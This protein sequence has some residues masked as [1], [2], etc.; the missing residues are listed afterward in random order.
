M[1]CRSQDVILSYQVEV[2]CV[3]AGPFPGEADAA[4]AGEESAVESWPA[5]SWTTSWTPTCP[6]PRATS[7][8][9]WTPTWPRLILKEWSDGS[10]LQTYTEETNSLINDETEKNRHK[11]RVTHN[12]SA[13]KSV[14]TPMH[15]ELAFVL[16]RWTHRR[17][18]SSEIRCFP[19]GEQ[20]HAMN[21]RARCTHLHSVHQSP[22]FLCAKW[23][24]LNWQG[25]PALERLV[26]GPE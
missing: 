22:L 26:N 5:S 2:G 23:K 21:V 4:G 3:G 15:F 9:S 10:L 18:K 12:Y 1:L 13:M 11:N 7:T 20:H 24:W 8:P 6:R 16:F 25:L 17:P 19:E 14:Q